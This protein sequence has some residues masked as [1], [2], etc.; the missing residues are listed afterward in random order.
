M[1]IGYFAFNASNG[2]SMVNRD[3]TLWE[4]KYEN[5]LW[6]IKEIEKIDYDKL[7]LL[8][9]ARWIGSGKEKLTGDAVETTSLASILLSQS[10]INIFSTVHTFAYKP[11]AIAHS[12]VFLNETFSNRYGINLVSGWK[13]DELNY[14]GI[15]N[16]ELENRY[17]NMG[18]WVE[19]FKNSEMQYSRLRN[20]ENFIP[21]TLLNAAFSEEGRKFANKYVDYLFSTLPNNITDASINKLTELS[22]QFVAFSLFFDEDIEIAI[23]K[24]HNTL[25][26]S[27]DEAALEFANF[28]K[29][30]D[31]KKGALYKMNKNLVKSGSGMPVLIAD[32]E[33]LENILITLYKHNCEGVAIS[34]NNYHDVEQ[35]NK[36]INKVVKKF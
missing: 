23:R 3:N 33:V 27:S 8:P 17:K 11:Q 19:E 21:T 4:A 12:S 29:K 34:L 28:I 9:I 1:Q 35:I 32:Y 26:I 16:I 25:K 13:E 31:S 24:Y 10:R 6:L 2:I 18:L 20:L 7:F 22:K 14:F 36:S 15:N 5:F 30:S